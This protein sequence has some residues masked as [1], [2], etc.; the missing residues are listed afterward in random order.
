MT[1]RLFDGWLEEIGREHW[2]L[3]SFA[4]LFSALINCGERSNAGYH[5][6]NLKPMAE[7]FLVTV[8]GT[9]ACILHVRGRCPVCEFLF[10][11]KA[12]RKE[13]VFSYY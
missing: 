1:I 13:G 11:S 5:S 10:A 9:Y 6:K 2:K 3:D 12:I 7:I 4:L 8:I